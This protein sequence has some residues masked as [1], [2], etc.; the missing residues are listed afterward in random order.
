LSPTAQSGLGGNGCWDDVVDVYVR[1]EVDEV[2]D[3]EAVDEASSPVDVLFPVLPTL[4]PDP[5]PR[6][7][8]IPELNRGPTISPPSTL[9]PF[10]PMT[11]P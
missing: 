7:I 2:V 5:E 3:D 10:I 9:K 1:R 6:L 4:V 11:P 8:P